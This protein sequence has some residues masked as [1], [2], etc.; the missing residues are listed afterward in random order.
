MIHRLSVTDG[1]GHVD[2]TIAPDLFIFAAEFPREP[3]RA[4]IAMFSPAFIN[5]SE[6]EDMGFTIWPETSAQG[7]NA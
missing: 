3:T 6:G 1:D 2:E 5:Q 4:G 7:C